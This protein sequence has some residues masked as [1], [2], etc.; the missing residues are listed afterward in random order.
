MADSNSDS[1]SD[2][3][4][5]SLHTAVHH[6]KALLHPLSP[7]EIQDPNDWPCFL[8]EQACVYDKH[9]KRVNLLEVGIRGPF[10]ATGRLSF[11]GDDGSLRARC[12][13]QV[14]L[15]FFLLYVMPRAHPKIP[16]RLISSRQ[17][18]SSC[19][20]SPTRLTPTK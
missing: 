6:H 18:L 7:F 17:V 2:S 20:T 9:G 1:D 13:P 5:E 3:D 19:S 16:R 14:K 10:K 11:E 12:K 8:L 4:Y 15:P